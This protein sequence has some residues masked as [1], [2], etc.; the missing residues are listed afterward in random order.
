MIEQT[1]FTCSLLG[2]AFKKLKE[3]RKI[4]EDQKRKRVLSLKTCW[5]AKAKIN[6]KHLQKSHKIKLKSN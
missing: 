1:K 4:I 5:I 6:W 3:K 2:K